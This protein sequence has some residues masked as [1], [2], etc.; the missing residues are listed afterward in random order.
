MCHHYISHTNTPNMQ[1][2]SL[3]QRAEDVNKQ[4]L[5]KFSTK[6]P[7]RGKLDCHMRQSKKYWWLELNPELQEKLTD[8]ESQRVERAA[9]QVAS[10]PS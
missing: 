4:C 5:Y 7:T 8:C 2:Y 3:Q 1:K 9:M 10:I 6:I